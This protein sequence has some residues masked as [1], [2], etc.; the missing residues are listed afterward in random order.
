MKNK[1]AAALLAFFWGCLGIHKFYLGAI[2]PGLLYLLFSWTFIPWFLGIIDFIILITMSNEKFNAKYNNKTV[3]MECNTSS[4]QL[5]KNNNTQIPNIITSHP[6]AP[7][8]IITQNSKINVMTKKGRKQCNEFVVVDFETTG[9]NVTDKI[10]E[11]AA[12]KYKDNNM[13][14]SFH[15]LVN[16]EVHISSRITKINGIN[17]DM[18]K[19]APTI[20]KVMPEF[21]EFIGDNIIVAHN[22]PFDMKFLKHYSS[23][24]NINIDNP[25]VDTLPLSRKVFTELEN[26]KL[27]TIVKHLNLNTEKLHRSYADSKCCAEILLHCLSIKDEKDNEQK[28]YK[29]M[30]L[31]S[32]TCDRNLLG[33]ELEKEGYIDNAIEL[34][35]LNAKDGFDGNHPYD[36]LSI[37]YRKNKNYVDEVRI[38]KRA[39]EVFEKANPLR[40][41]VLPKLTKFRIRLDKAIELL[42]NNKS[43]INSI[44]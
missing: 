43:D 1:T 31:P 38:L 20:D 10:V 8:P 16:P 12:L 36:R 41:D 30:K 23:L 24:C 42:K 27:V 13:V 14:D 40:G 39:I 22:A 37:I 19:D 3:K 17:D 29:S 34:Y 15:S 5:Y 6:I 32:D 2:K 44:A 4:Q 35:E 21:A 7:Q 9:L 26:H 33:I 18:V 28:P 11:V 25:V